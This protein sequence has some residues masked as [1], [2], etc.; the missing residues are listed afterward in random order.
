MDVSRTCANRTLRELSVNPYRS[1]TLREESVS[2]PPYYSLLYTD[3]PVF[4][5]SAIE[6]FRS[7]LPDCGTLCAERH[8][9]VANVCSYRKRLNSEDA[10]L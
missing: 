8:V 6:L 1:T 10:S 4:Q 7:L 5:P 9:G 3:A 2:L